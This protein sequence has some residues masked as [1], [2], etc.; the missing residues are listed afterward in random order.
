MGNDFPPLCHST[1]NFLAPAT[2]VK[3]LFLDPC[4]C[5]DPQKIV[6]QG[7][8]MEITKNKGKVC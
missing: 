8:E 4:T 1:C 2:A 6:I 5:N 3:Y 7:I